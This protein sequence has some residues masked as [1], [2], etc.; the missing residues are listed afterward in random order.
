MSS[1]PGL[2]PP[3]AARRYKATSALEWVCNGCGRCVLDPCYK[4][5][6]GM[7]AKLWTVVYIDDATEPTKWAIRRY[8]PKCAPRIRDLI[9]GRHD[10]ARDGEE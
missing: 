7:E 4:G 9:L 2:F 5:F 3:E 1:N 10:G 6:R 8:C